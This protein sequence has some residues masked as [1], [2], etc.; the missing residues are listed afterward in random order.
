MMSRYT[1]KLH[2]ADHLGED[3][4]RLIEMIGMLQDS[5]ANRTGNEVIGAVLKDLVE[6]SRT[7]FP[8]EED[9]M[10]H[11]RYGDFDRHRNMHQEFTKRLADILIRIKQGKE[12]TVYELIFF[13]KKWVD[14]H[15]IIEDLKFKRSI[16]PK[17]EPVF[18]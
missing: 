13:L 10:M 4:F 17:P 7:H 11:H 6:Y 2:S 1:Q 12:V 16:E 8:Q 18:V 9:F 5:I 14:D 15:L 3:N